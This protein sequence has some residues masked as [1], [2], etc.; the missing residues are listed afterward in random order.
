MNDAVERHYKVSVPISADKFKTT[1]GIKYDVVL[2]GKQK[3]IKNA[4]ECDVFTFT[5]SGNRTE[6][7]ITSIEFKAGQQITRQT[8][9]GCQSASTVAYPVTLQ[10]RVTEQ[11]IITALNVKAY[12]NPYTD[13]VRFEINSPQAGQGS[14]EVFNVLGQKVKTIY[15]GHIIKGTQLFELNVPA[16]FPSTLIY[17]FSVNGKQVTGKLMS[18]GD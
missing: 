11:T 4:G 18:A 10:N 3:G 14:L 7:D 15:Q 16:R 12:P 17:R 13:K 5:L 9:T 1:W 6:D 8:P 2:K